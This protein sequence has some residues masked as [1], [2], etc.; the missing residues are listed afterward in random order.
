M[1]AGLSGAQTVGRKSNKATPL[2]SRHRSYFPTE[3]LGVRRMESTGAVMTQLHQLAEATGESCGPVAVGSVTGAS[4][5]DVEKAIRQAAAEDNQ[6][7]ADLR[8]TRLRTY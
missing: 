8:D 7:P 4:A 3:E 1:V 2:Q 5:E 6:Y